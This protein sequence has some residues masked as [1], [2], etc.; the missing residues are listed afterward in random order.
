MPELS[1]PVESLVRLLLDMI[2]RTWPTTEDDRHRFYER[3]GLRQVDSSAV[4]RQE[5]DRTVSH[6]FETSLVG[7]EGIDTMFGGEFLGLSL[8]AYNEPGD[9]GV[10]SRT[11]YPLLKDAIS[12][13]LGSPAE[14]WGTAREPACYWTAGEL[15]LEMYCFQRLASGVM[16]GPSHAERSAANDREAADAQR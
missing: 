4:D 5:D 3:L 14:E 2:K 13:R 1:P 11:A 9:D 6:W 10:E 8:F 7:V 16:L 12:L 15:Q